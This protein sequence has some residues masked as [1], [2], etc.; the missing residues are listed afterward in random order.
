MMGTSVMKPILPTFIAP[1]QAVPRCYQAGCADWNV[2]R[3]DL[4]DMA[5]RHYLKRKI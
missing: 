5:T 1:P 3:Q 4:I 2:H